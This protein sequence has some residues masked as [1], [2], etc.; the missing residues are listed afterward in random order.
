MRARW[1]LGVLS[2]AHS[3]WECQLGLV[4]GSLAYVLLRCVLLR[5]LPRCVASCILASTATRTKADAVFAVSSRMEGEG[6]AKKTAGQAEHGTAQVD[7]CEAA[8][9]F[10]VIARCVCTCAEPVSSSCVSYEEAPCVLLCHLLFK[11]ALSDMYSW[12]QAKGYTEGAG[13][14]LMGGCALTRIFAK[15]FMH[16][17]V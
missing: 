16:R 9:L 2:L 17:N 14:S 8:L 15:H 4:L 1:K 10:S 12:L 5:L 13:D 7:S 3:C 6:A 11:C